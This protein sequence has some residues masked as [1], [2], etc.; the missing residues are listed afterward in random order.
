[1]DQCSALP[2]MSWEFHIYWKSNWHLHCLIRPFASFVRVPTLIVENG[3]S[4]KVTIV[5]VLSKQFYYRQVVLW[6]IWISRPLFSSWMCSIWRHLCTVAG[7]P[8]AVCHSLLSDNPGLWLERGFIGLLCF[9][10]CPLDQIAP[11][12]CRRRRMPCLRRYYDA[13]NINSTKVGSSLPSRYS[14]IPSFLVSKHFQS[15]WTP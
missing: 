10:T 13:M 6:W 14:Q 1:M 7:E 8:S 5:Q 11:S 9:V 12:R 2:R 4:G 3:L 15:P